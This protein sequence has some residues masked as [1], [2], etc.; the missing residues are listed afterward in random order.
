[1]KLAWPHLHTT[2]PDDRLRSRSGPT[3]S[4]GDTHLVRRV[5]WR[6]VAWSGAI[7]LLILLVLGTA[8]YVSVARSLEATGTQTLRARADEIRDAIVYGSSTPF[9][10]RFP[11]RIGFDFGGPAPGTYAMVIGPNGAVLGAP[12][13]VA[14]LPNSTGITAAR[15]SGT[16]LQ[17]TTLDGE[18]VWIISETAKAGGQTYVVQ[19]VGSRAA[20]QRTLDI[21]LEVLAVG[22]LAA[23]LLALAAGTI[24]ASRALV[25]IRESLRRQ[26]EFAADASHELRTPLTVVRTSLDYLRHHADETIDA[27]RETIDDI[28]TEV[29]H[30]TGLV[31]SLL[32]LARADSGALEVAAEPLDLADVAA[33]AL[34]G[35]GAMAD[36]RAIS[37]TLD[38]EPT[39]VSGD[40]L[41]LRQLVTI[42]AD[43]A[44]RY[45]RDGGVVVVRIRPEEHGARLEVED[46][47]PGIPSEYRE[48]VFER[49]WRAPGAAPGGTGLGLSIATW[50]AAQHG[51][52]LALEERPGG[53]SRFVA[54]LGSSSAD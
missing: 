42:L 20:E 40:P 13:A 19:V 33:S 14:G 44:I 17:Q 10:T 54:H 50:V 49:F 30:L 32:V 28:G 51:G 22:G 47:G 31:D 9:G 5:R 35:L 25:P 37:L 24:Y 46:D 3:E 23:L 21:L 39:Q 2:L 4:A 18:P 12:E 26:R 43:N 27:H 41:R 6:L 15:A 16:N 36:R 29:D 52:S 45:G 7:T 53:G 38:A 8:V 48:Q 11:V 34:G 1:M